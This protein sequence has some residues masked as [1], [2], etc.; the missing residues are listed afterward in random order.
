M[1]QIE[2]L[3]TTSQANWL[4]CQN[5]FLAP[6]SYYQKVE[7]S[8][9]ELLTHFKPIGNALD[10]GCG[11]GRF[12]FVLAKYCDEII[13][14]DISTHLIHEASQ[15]A[16]QMAY[17]YLNIRFAV[18]S[19]LHYQPYTTY[20]MLS[21]M[22]VT[23]AFID[24]NLYL[25]VLDKLARSVREHGLLLLRET[26]HKG[27]QPIVKTLPNYIAIYRPYLDYIKNIQNRGFRMLRALTLQEE[28]TT[29]NQL[30]LFKKQSLHL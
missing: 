15:L 23:N 14:Y 4:Q 2:L 20:D 21:C 27:H 25:Q 6:E 26:M 7:I 18:A 13:G 3:Q 29:I 17:G 8:L 9:H 1:E 24:E 30:M 19:L 11:N 5:T 12:T 16:Y 10:F 22:G 28:E